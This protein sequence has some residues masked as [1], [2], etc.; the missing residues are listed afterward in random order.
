MSP[1]AP[2]A[3]RWSRPPLITPAPMPVATF[4]NSRC[5]TSAYSVACSPSAMMFTSLSTS[6]GPGSSRLSRP[7]TSYESQPGM[8][9][10]WFGRPVLCSTGPGQS[11]AG[12]GEVRDGPPCRSQQRRVPCARPRSGPPR[13]LRRCSSRVVD[14][15]RISPVRSVSATDR[16][17][18]P[19]SAARISRAVGL[20]R[21]RAGGRPPVDA[22]SPDGT[23]RPDREQRL[24]PAGHRRP[25]QAAEVDEFG[26]GPRLPVEEQAQYGRGSAVPRSLI[27]GTSVAGPLDFCLT[28]FKSVT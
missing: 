18:A 12:A 16:C 7:T 9:G 19:T 3:P 2:C 28:G 5:S 13:V 27:A 1:A 15:S 14:R 11:D 23:T 25:G 6:T 20:N 4:T 24:D 10:G 22:A 21:N 26:A 17:V 8:I